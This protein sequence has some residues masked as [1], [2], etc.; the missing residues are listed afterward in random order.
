MPD[1]RFRLLLNS[2]TFGQIGTE[3]NFFRCGVR[4]LRLLAG[5]ACG[6]AT[7]DA[8]AGP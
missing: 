6:R 7:A 3:A 1:A 5:A 4:V 8:D 2:L